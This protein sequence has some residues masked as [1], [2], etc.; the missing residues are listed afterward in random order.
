MINF[1]IAR[2]KIIKIIKKIKNYLKNPDIKLIKNTLGLA[3]RYTFF[4]IFFIFCLKSKK[5]KT[6]KTKLNI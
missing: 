6:P 2:I 4:G 1:L 5:K 3:A